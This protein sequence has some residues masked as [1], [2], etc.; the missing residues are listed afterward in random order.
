MIFESPLPRVTI[1]E[2]PL[3]E[4]V[5]QR[6]ERL[7]DKPA[8]VDGPTGRTVTFSQLRRDVDRL[9][10]ALHARGLRRGEPFAVFSPNLPEYPIAFHGVVRAGGVCTTINSLYTPREINFQLADAGARFLLTA[11]PFLERALEAIPGTSVQE[12]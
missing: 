11:P 10:G 5:L 2:A 8:L 4:V 6:A 3:T 12:V 1:P 9:A 7:G